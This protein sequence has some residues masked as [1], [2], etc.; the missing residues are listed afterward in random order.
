M[1]MGSEINSQS[2][3]HPPQFHQFSSGTD[4][5]SNVYSQ[6]PVG[7]QDSGQFMSLLEP[8]DHY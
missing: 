4:Q 8:K 2:S 5:V 1:E 3:S 6:Y 7:R